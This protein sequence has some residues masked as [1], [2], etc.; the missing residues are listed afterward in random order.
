[1]PP[2]ENAKLAS[3]TKRLLDRVITIIVL[4]NNH[5][6]PIHAKLIATKFRQ[7]HYEQ[8]LT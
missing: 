2:Q 8:P 7:A 3:S 1:M 5:Q 4:G 6:T